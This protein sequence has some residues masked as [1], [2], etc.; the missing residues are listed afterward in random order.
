MKTINIKQGEKK[1]KNL[2][3]ESVKLKTYGQIGR[4]R[5]QT[6]KKGFF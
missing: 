6:N 3:Q 5:K 1:K 4:L 2:K